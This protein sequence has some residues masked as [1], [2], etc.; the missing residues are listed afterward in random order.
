MYNLGLELTKNAQFFAPPI[1]WLH[2]VHRNVVL[3]ATIY[4]LN[5][6]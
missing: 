3:P 2:M 1:S 5:I 6:F 4:V